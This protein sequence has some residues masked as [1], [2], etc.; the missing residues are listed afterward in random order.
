M[1]FKTHLIH[2]LEKY[3]KPISKE[4]EYKLYSIYKPR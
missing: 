3:N 1:I 4:L 2:T